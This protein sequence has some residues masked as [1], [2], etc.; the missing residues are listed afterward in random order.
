[1]TPIGYIESIDRHHKLLDAN[2]ISLATLLLLNG[3]DKQLPRPF[4]FFTFSFE[5]SA[6]YNFQCTKACLGSQSR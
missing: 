3:P 6:D 4:N 5:T 2:C 1:M